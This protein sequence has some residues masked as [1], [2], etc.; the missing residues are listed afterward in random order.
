MLVLYVSIC[1]MHNVLL[2][3]VEEKLY[4]VHQKKQTKPGP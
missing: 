4:F 3:S 2:R 1:D